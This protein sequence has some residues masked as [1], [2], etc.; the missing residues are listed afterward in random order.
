MGGKSVEESLPG[1]MHDWLVDRG[2]TDEDFQIAGKLCEFEYQFR[3]VNGD[4]IWDAILRDS[5]PQTPEKPEIT[6]A[7]ALG[8]LLGIEHERSAKDRTA[9][10]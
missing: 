10:S 1:G 6:C 9:S 3:L 4:R 5:G 2:I 7:V 8:I